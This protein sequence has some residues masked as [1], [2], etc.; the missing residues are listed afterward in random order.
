MT[1]K[2]D[3]TICSDINKFNTIKHLVTVSCIYTK[4]AKNR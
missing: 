4:R 2:E 1:D 3:S